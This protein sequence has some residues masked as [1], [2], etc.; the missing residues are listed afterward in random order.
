M[1][2]VVIIGA[3]TAGTLVANRLA[4]QLSPNDTIIAIDQDNSH[5]YQ[6]GLLFVPFGKAKPSKLTRPR[7]GQLSKQVTY[8]QGSVANIDTKDNTV[9]LKDR[10]PIRYDVAVIASGSR[11]VIEETEGLI[12]DG[13]LKD[14][15][16]FYSLEGATALRDRLAGFTSGRI[17]VN[18]IDLPIKCPVAP[19][20]FC[21][22]L[23]AFFGDR[24][25]R[26]KVKITYVTPLDGAFTKPVCSSILGSMLHDRNIDLITEFNTGSV[27]YARNTLISY[28]GREVPF[29]LAVLIPPHTG[30]EFV[31]NSQDLGDDFGFIPTEPKSLVSKVAKNVFVIG[32]ATDIPASKAGS[33]AHFEGE[34]VCNNVL[35]YLRSEPLEETFD[36]HA[37][38]FIESGHNKAMLIDFNYETEPLP[39]KFPLRIGAP[40]LKESKLNHLGKLAFAWVY[41]H[42]LLKGRDI[43][44]IGSQ[45]PRSGKQ[46][47]IQPVREVMP[48]QSQPT[49]SQDSH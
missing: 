39:G 35:H 46:F 43:P 34:V 5:L 14:A 1:S 26:D 29:D 11:I 4:K 41:W 13:W 31:F 45:M 36:G 17:V 19:L 2:T 33:V 38:C 20:E 28:D 8:I 15:F 44:L 21:F 42:V 37:N 3:G 30:A 49:Q 24:S 7:A 25:I 23:D 32:D 18:V 9:V 47:L 10:P 27:D 16:T 48:T 6:P 12:G 40:L 22:L